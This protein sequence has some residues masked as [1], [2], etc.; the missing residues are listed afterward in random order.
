MWSKNCDHHEEIATK[1]DKISDKME[2]K[3]DFLQT[4]FDARHDKIIKAINENSKEIAV[5]KIKQLG[6]AVLAGIGGSQLPQG[7]KEL[8]EILKKIFL[9]EY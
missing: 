4:H 5:L 8:L 1:L 6:I 3:F 2:R 9:T 7:L